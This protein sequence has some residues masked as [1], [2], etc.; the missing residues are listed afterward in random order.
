MYPRYIADA[1]AT[2][3]SK[4]SQTRIREC[5]FLKVIL[6]NDYIPIVYLLYISGENRTCIYYTLY[7]CG[8]SLANSYINKNHYN[9]QLTI[10]KQNEVHILSIFMKNTPLYK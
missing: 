4:I 3:N 1:P 5:E 2:Y 7:N 8:V 10:F 6:A 9:P